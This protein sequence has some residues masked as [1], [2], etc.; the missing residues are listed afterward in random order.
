MVALTPQVP[1]P[2][3]LAR[4]QALALL[5]R[6]AELPGLAAS[7]GALLLKVSQVRFPPGADASG[8]FQCLRESRPV[9]CARVAVYRSTAPATSPPACPT[10][11][12]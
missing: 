11:A 2:C 6:L 10:A 9:R 8:R 12:A 3:R 4:I 7:F 5:Q 1:W